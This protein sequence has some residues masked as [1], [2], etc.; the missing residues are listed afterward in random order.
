MD[1]KQIIRAALLSFFFVAIFFTTLLINITKPISPTYTDAG[2]GI[3]EMK[4]I[5]DSI[6]SLNFQ[7]VSTLPMFSGLKNNL[8]YSSNA[9]VQSLLALPFYV[10]TKNIFVTFNLFIILTVFLN[11]F[12]IYLLVQYLF[13]N[14]WASTLAAVIG[15][16]NPYVMTFIPDSMDLFS[17]E[18]T[19]LALLFFERFLDTERDIDIFIFFIF[20]AIKLISG[21]YYT[22]FITVVFPIYFILRLK[23]KNK[24]LRIFLKKGTALGF[25]VYLLVVA[26][27][28]TFYGATYLRERVIQNLEQTAMAYSAFVLDWFVAPTNNFLYGKFGDMIRDAAP[29]IFPFLHLSDVSFFWGFTLIVLFLI[30][31]KIFK[32]SSRRNL[33]IGYIILLLISI[34]MSF[35]PTIHLTRYFGIPGPYLLVYYINPL[36]QFIRVPSRFAFFAFFFL[37]LLIALTLDEMQKRLSAHRGKIIA[38]LIITFVVLEL[39]HKPLKSETIPENTR[40]FYSALRENKQIQLIVDLPIAN[41]ILEIY[42]QSRPETSDGYYLYWATIHGKTLLNGYSAFIPKKFFED[43]F[44]LNVDF[45]TK[46]KIDL[47]RELNVDAIVLHKNQYKDPKEYDRIKNGLSE[48]RVP[49]LLSTKELSLFDLTSL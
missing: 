45:P 11:F 31:F 21:F 29:A 12:S 30:S 15:T 42:P 26:T 40:K 38:M 8:F 43:T 16:F 41:R 46:E 35:G 10:A 22:V 23:Q 18:W 36:F 39:Y 20:L 3:F 7:D 4:H 25:G 47:L 9:L 14:S 34:V 2:L 48:L 49:L 32:K 33:W 28:G 24:S 1:K 19:P 5:L 13:K 17:L 44:F 6:L 27:I 37:A